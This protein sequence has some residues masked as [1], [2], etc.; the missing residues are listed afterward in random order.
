MSTTPEYKLVHVNDPAIAVAVAP[1]QI[2]VMPWDGYLAA[3]GSAGA[4]QEDIQ[5]SFSDGQPPQHGPARDIAIDTDAQVYMQNDPLMHS[6]NGG[7][8]NICNAPVQKN[9]IIY[10]EYPNGTGTAE[11]NIWLLITKRPIG[12]GAYHLLVA[13]EDTIA[14]GSIIMDLPMAI[15]GISK[16]SAIFIRGAG[17]QDM[18]VQIGAQGELWDTFG[19]AIA[20]DTDACPFNWFP[21]DVDLGPDL[22]TVSFNGYSGVAMVYLI[23]S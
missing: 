23:L 13:A 17:A 3:F 1:I 20:V 7:L 15:P 16:I 6:L 19:R 14:A 21:V 9:T 10:A 22:R 4:G 11:G 5:L 2:F 12:D 18:V 8:L